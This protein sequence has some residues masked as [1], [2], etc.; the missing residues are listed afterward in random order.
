[1]AAPI[2]VIF[3]KWLTAFNSGDKAAI[4]AFYG[5]Y[6]DDP[7]P[8]YALDTAE[9]TCGFD[10]VRTEEQTPLAMRV[11]LAE[12]C[13]PTLQRLTI[14]FAAKDDA[15]PKTFK[16]KS[17][18]LS[19][20]GAIDAMTG[21]ADRLAARD[22][23]AGSLLVAHGDGLAWSQ[24]WGQLD[25]TTKAPI[26]PD[27]PMFLASAG[28]MFT[29]VA[30]L[31]LVQ[32]G[33]VDLEA[34]FGRYLTDYP[35]KDMAKVTIRQLLQHRAGTGDIGV[36]ARDEGDNR[37]RIRTID[38]IIALNGARAPLFPPG[39]KTDYSNYGF[40]LLGAVVERVSGESYYEYVE[41]HI[42][43]PAGM[44]N[45]GF[46]DRDHL[47]GVATG[48]TT[49]FGEEPEL[50]SNVDVLPW[51]G[52]PAG[53]GVASANDMLKFFRALT[54]GKLLS[55]EMLRLAT[56]VG[57]T[58]WY[59]LGFVVDSGTRSQWGHGGTSYG[60]DVAAYSY[61]ENDTI[62]VCLATRDMACNRLFFAWHHRTFG[63]TK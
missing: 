60:M 50:I 22:K 10:V 41:R 13:F 55:R 6:L 38:E 58:P 21:T 19:N 39:S 35:N 63:L 12:R 7:D 11:L 40:L 52:T 61:P 47:A 57:D 25:K 17:F 26:T 18:A 23:F 31:Q 32:K 33:K 3:R 42:F 45:A 15:K 51:R 44:A 28:K 8:A 46:P 36:L 49:F 24:S 29:A 4:R 37:A 5:T 54:A 27:T 34:P 43:T 20:Q 48:Y 59:G 9:D 14:E 1:M 53:G 2:D 56:T 62:Y 30:V 16:L